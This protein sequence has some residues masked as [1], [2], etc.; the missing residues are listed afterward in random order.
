LLRHGRREDVAK[1][2]ASQS[3]CRIHGKTMP[4]PSDISSCRV[5]PRHAVRTSR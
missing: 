1:F 4:R 2:D 5:G 3:F